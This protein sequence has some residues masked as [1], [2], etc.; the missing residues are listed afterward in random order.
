MSIAGL[1]VIQPKV[2]ADDRGYFYESYNQAR[3]DDEIGR[4]ITFVQDNQSLSARGVLRGLHYQVTPHPQ[5]K[6]VRCVNGAVWD[7]A[8]DI[9]RSS[10]TFGEWFGLDLTEDNH[11]QLWIPE[12]F[13]HGFVARSDDAVLAYKTTDYYHSECD[14]SIHWNDPSIGVLWPLDGAPLVSPKDESAPRLDEA[15]VFE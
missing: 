1:R 4:A 12:G 13:A 2:F 15:E 9:R 7:V 8:V 6:L 11:T 3:F 5:G 10:P 14:R